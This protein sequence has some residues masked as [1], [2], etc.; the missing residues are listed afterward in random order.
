[1]RADVAK[2]K[3]VDRLVSQTVDTLGQVDILFNNAGI[4]EFAT[5]EE[6]SDEM[7]HRPEDSH[8]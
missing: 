7:W 5:L 4:A 2:S 6:H 1:M 3:D 8:G